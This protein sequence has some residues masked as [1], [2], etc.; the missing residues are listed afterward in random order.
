MDRCPSGIATS[1]VDMSIMTVG[2][3]VIVP[4]T[5]LVAALAGFRPLARTDHRVQTTKDDAS[6]VAR[7]GGDSG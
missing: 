5:L 7:M 2:R 4:L 6:D 3:T 1:G